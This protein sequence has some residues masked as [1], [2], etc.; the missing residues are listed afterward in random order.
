MLLK[1][2]FKQIYLFKG[3]QTAL[4]LAAEQGHEDVCKWLINEGL[5]Q[6]YIR[7]KEGKTA[8][9]IARIHHPLKLHDLIIMIDHLTNQF[10]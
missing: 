6:P 1:L 2:F 10:A 5:T 8:A 9:D 3:G 7:D 4:M